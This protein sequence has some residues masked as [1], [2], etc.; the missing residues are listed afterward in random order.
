MT[1]RARVVLITGVPGSGKTTL[2]TEI[3]RALQIPFLARD[4][5][6]RGMFFTR[7]AWTA[8]PGPLPTRDEAVDTFLRI[9][10]TIASQGVSCVVEYV[11]PRERPADLGRLVTAG[12]CVVVI[13]GCRDP[14]GR[15]A[16][17]ERGDRLLNRQPVLDAL[18]GATIDDLMGPALA[19]MR[20]VGER[21]QTE[22]DLPVLRV[23][24]DDGYD[25]PIEAVLAF[26][27]AEPADDWAGPTTRP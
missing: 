27:T 13:T 17:R 15:V 20:S 5:V 10:E 26:V 4:D 25:P 11:V 16:R 1:G 24:T 22:F 7:G 21:M 19:R 12:D 2:G 3:S 8:R 9:V 6:R 14:L 23:T 18:G